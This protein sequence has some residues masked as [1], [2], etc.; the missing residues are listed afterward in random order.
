MGGMVPL[1]LRKWISATADDAA[2]FVEMGGQH[3]PGC[4]LEY[5]VP[6]ASGW[7]PNATTKENVLDSISVSR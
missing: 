3:P 1:A 7:P 2:E 6:I 4:G 5:G